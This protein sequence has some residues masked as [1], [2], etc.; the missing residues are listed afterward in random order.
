MG[1]PHT[2]AAGLVER[3]GFVAPLLP[4]LDESAAAALL[5]LLLRATSKEERDV[6]GSEHDE[7]V[8]S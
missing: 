8:R 4:L 2:D 5:N 6:E 3:P 7:G 1:E